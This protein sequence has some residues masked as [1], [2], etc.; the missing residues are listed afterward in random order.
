M[1]GIFIIILILAMIGAVIYMTRK[2]S[3]QRPINNTMNKKATIKL[4][5]NESDKRFANKTGIPIP[6]LKDCIEV[7]DEMYLWRRDEKEL[8]IISKGG[9]PTS[10]RLPVN[11]NAYKMYES[12]RNYLY[13]VEEWEKK[14]ELGKMLMS[15]SNHY[16][17]EQ[18]KWIKKLGL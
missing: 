7:Y 2:E 18:Y 1:A 6:I 11:Q 16:E 9:Q 3:K 12:Y 17:K 13:D 8:E 10:R 4:N 15:F 14:D 5:L